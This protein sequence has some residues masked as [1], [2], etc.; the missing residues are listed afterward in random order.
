MSAHHAQPT[1]PEMIKALTRYELE[2]IAAG[3]ATDDL[4][5][6]IEFFV[7]GGFNAWSDNQ[8]IRKYREDIAEG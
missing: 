3:N 7:K 6:C 1:R 5:D 4:G 8:L 2:F